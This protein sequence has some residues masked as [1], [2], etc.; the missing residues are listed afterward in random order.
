M[1]VVS[2]AGDTSNF[3]EYEDDNWQNAAGVGEE[4]MK[5]FKDF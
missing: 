3:D 1:P 4:E 5:A 2:H